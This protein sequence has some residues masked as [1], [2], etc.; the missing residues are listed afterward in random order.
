[1]G[2]VGQ[3]PE[4]LILFFHPMELMRKMKVYSVMSMIE[5]KEAQQ[6]TGLTVFRV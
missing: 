5:S 2:K 6:H 3:I 4:V 1:M